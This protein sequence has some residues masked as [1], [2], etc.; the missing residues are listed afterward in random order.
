MIV[1]PSFEWIFLVVH[2]IDVR[3]LQTELDKV[4]TNKVPTSSKMNLI[5]LVS[6]DK[7]KEFS[8]IH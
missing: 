7:I 1:F 4:V 5:S 2:F 3:I 6:D 8:E